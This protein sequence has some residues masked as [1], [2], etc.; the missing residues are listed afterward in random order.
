MKK[1]TIILSLALLGLINNIDAQM[2]SWL[3][4]KSVDGAYAQNVTVDSIG[5]IYVVGTFKPPYSLFDSIVLTSV[6]Y[7]YDIYVVKYNSSGDILWAKSA[8]GNDDDGVSSI[9]IDKSGNVYVA[10]A[11]NSTS[12]TFDSITLINTSDYNE[13]DGFIAKYDNNGNVLWAKSAS[14]K[15][16]EEVRSISADPYGN[17]YMTGKFESSSIIFG[18]TTLINSSFSINMFIVKYNLD[19]KVLWAK[20]ASGQSANEAYSVSTDPSGNVYMGGNFGGAPISFGSITLAYVDSIYWDMF[21]AKYDSSGNVLWAKSSG[22]NSNDRIFSITS[23]TF[24]NI[25]VS[26]YFSSTSITFGS[27]T[28]TNTNIYNSFIVKYDSNGNAL[29]AKSVVPNTTCNISADD[30]GNIYAIGP[31][32]SDSITFDTITLI[33]K[34]AYDI[35]VVKFDSNGNALWAKSVGGSDNDYSY[36]GTTDNSQNLYM[37]GHYESPTITFGP[38]TLTGIGYNMFIAKL[39]ECNLTKPTISANDSILTSSSAI[40]NQWYLNDSIIVGDT[41]QTY[42]STQ[43]GNYTVVVTYGNGCSASSDP[44][45]YSTSEIAEFTTNN[46]IIIIPN[47]SDGKFRIETNNLKTGYMEIYNSLGEIIYQSIIDNREINLSQQPKGL[48]FIEM[49]MGENI[50]DQKLIIQ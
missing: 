38:T 4:A 34:G 28:L 35:F 42:I 22:G 9:A 23:D 24:S 49:M 10:G 46:D 7:S 29:W 11:F 37:V 2:Q 18:T 36:D 15:S 47:P 27:T 16:D 8:G 3:W 32:N 25:Y 31:F 30:Q 6:N 50:Y 12:I 33:N 21:I 40:G 39:S 17:I 41:S 43:N 13:Y 14:G 1:L 19:G 48:Y 45:N 44:Y 26:G 5:N 20:S